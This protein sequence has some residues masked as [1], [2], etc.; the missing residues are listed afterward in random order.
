MSWT[1]ILTAVTAAIL[2]TLPAFAETLDIQQELSQPGVKL[3]VVEFYAT[4]CKH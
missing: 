1:F 2:F 4:W 3:L